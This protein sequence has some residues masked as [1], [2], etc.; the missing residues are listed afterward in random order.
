MFPSSG[1]GSLPAIAES[2][3]EG[4]DATPQGA[5]PDP[6][7]DHF[8][9]LSP[10]STTGMAGE[11]M[12]HPVPSPLYACRTD[13]ALRRPARRTSH[14]AAFALLACAL[15]TVEAQ[16]PL[17]NLPQAARLGIL[18]TIIVLVIASIVACCFCCPG[19]PIA[20]RRAARRAG[21]V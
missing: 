21:R 17:Q 6:P 20:R 1:E 15:P 19:C 10:L 11:P 3:V 12:P 18:I 8:S 9:P 5:L 16:R 14:L 7:P 4:P 13:S 2:R